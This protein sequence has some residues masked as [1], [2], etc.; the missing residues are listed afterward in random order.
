MTPEDRDRV[1]RVRAKLQNA[2]FVPG[3]RRLNAPASERDRAMRVLREVLNDAVRS[4][5]EVL[6]EDACRTG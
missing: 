6:E 3:V 1:A 2:R 4:L 5:D